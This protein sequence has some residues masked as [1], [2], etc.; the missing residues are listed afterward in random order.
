MNLLKRIR[1]YFCK[2]KNSYSIKGDKYCPDCQKIKKGAGTLEVEKAVADL[3]STYIIPK[4][5]VVSLQ[6]FI[7]R[8][9]R[10]YPS[11]HR[12]KIFLRAIMYFK[13]QKR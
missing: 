3:F 5:R 2:H 9:Q 12:D 13:F 6:R 7:K 1:N 8:T 11:M 10:D 4:D